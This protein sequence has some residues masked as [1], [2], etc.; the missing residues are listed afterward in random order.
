M[1]RNDKSN[2]NRINERRRNEIRLTN[3]L[4]D[5]DSS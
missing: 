2:K 4:Q 1:K 5:E 3:V